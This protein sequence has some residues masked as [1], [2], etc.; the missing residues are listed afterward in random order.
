VQAAPT[1]PTSENTLSTSLSVHGL[2]AAS[3][4]HPEE[5][6]HPERRKSACRASPVRQVAAVVL[7]AAGVATGFVRSGDHRSGAAALAPPRLAAFLDRHSCYDERRHGLSPPQPE[8][9][10]RPETY[11]QGGREAGAQG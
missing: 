4:S 3:V 11:E 10:V 2:K 6:Q 1:S 5:E 8:Q 9:G 7:A